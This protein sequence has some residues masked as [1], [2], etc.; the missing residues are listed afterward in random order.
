MGFGLAGRLVP[1]SSS[2]MSLVPEFALSSFVSL[3]APIT[4]LSSTASGNFVTNRL[5]SGHSGATDVARAALE[6]MKYMLSWSSCPKTWWLALARKC[7]NKEMQYF[8]GFPSHYLKH[9]L[10]IPPK[11]IFS[12]C[13]APNLRHIML[14]IIITSGGWL[15]MLATSYLLL[16]PTLPQVTSDHSI[17]YQVYC[18]PH[19]RMWLQMVYGNE[20]SFWSTELWLECNLMKQA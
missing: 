10:P 13:L 5:T 9:Q 3:V 4:I 2:Q 17:M 20:Y 16:L 7:M 18:I 12:L 8:S 19:I 1:S 15:W 11:S 14:T 6:S